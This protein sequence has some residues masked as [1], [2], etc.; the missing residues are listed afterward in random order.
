[1]HILEKIVVD[2]YAKATTDILIGYHFRKIQQGMAQEPLYPK[3]NQFSTHIPRIVVFW[4]QQL[5]LEVPVRF[6]SIA[7]Q[8]TAFD[9]LN[10]HKLLNIKKGELNRWLL[11]FRQTIDESAHLFPEE[12]ELIKRWHQKIDHFEKIFLDKFF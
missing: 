10:V 2:F 11:L 1:M 8:T 12:T 3:L 4:S 5:G 6:R 7:N 9:I